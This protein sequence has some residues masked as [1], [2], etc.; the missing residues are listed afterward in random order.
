MPDSNVTVEKSASNSGWSL[1]GWIYRHGEK[2]WWLHSLYALL[3]GV[4]MMW[5][6]TR[7]FAY[8]RIAVFH[9]SFIWLSS[10]LLPKLLEHQRLPARWVPRVRLLVNFLNKNFYQ[11]VLFFVLPIYYASATPGSRNIAFVALVGLSATLSTLD[12]VYDRHLSV[13]RGLTAVFFAFNLFALINVMLPVLWSVSNTS[14]TRISALLAL[15]GFLTLYS[16]PAAS[17]TRRIAFGLLIALLLV[18]LIEGGRSLIPPAP[19]RLVKAEFGSGF[20]EESLQVEPVI[21][22][23]DPGG[24]QRLY[25]VTA[26]RAPLGLKEKVQHRWY[27]NGKLIFASPF[28]NMI[29]GREQGFR[30]WTA[31][32]LHDIS[33]GGELR[34]DLQTEGGQLIGRAG[35]KAGNSRRL[36]PE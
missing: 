32:T 22:R 34:L 20:E 16:P 28:Y 6:G 5:L 31:C 8:L 23:L 2:F 29:G 19:L 17:T 36:S 11:Q 33:P 27:Q 13:K 30:L 25:G 10:L 3:L 1:F 35:L 18:G 9:I 15:I 21:T 7:K 26:I 24:S 12:L 4:G 14:T